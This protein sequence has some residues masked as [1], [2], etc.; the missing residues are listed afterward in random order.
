MTPDL[1]TTNILLGVM[2]VSAVLGLLAIAAVC[3]AAF[4]MFR[5]VTQLLAR[6]EEQHV[7][8]AAVRV[9]AILDDVHTISATLKAQAAHLGA[10]TRWMTVLWR[11]FG[12]NE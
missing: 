4:L 11:I 3:V 12:K 10:A 7:T 5:R 1:S 9:R 8:P 2:A 6:I